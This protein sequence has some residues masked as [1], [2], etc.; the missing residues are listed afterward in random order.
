MRICLFEDPGVVNLEPLALTRPAFELLCGLTSLGRKQCRHFAPCEVGVLVRPELADLCRAA[1]PSLRVNDLGWLRAEQTVL[2][3]GRWLPPAGTIDQRCGPCAGMVGDEIAYA[4]IHADQLSYCSPNTIGDCLQ[5][6]KETLPSCQAGGRMIGYLWDLVALNGEQ[7][8]QDFDDMACP[9]SA[10]SPRGVAIVGPGEHCLIDPTAR[11]DPMVVI[12]T[13]GGPVVIDREA[14][15][16]AFTRIEGPC[17]I[18]P[19][20][21]LFG[22]K[23]RAGTTL[24]PQCRVGGEVECSIIHGHSNKYHDGFL[25]H[26]YVGEWVNLGAATNNSDLRNDYGRVSVWAA[27]RLVNTGQT[28]VGCFLGDHTKT[29]LGTLLNTGTNA[30]VFCNLLPSG[31]YLPRRVPSFTSWWN[32]ELRDNSDVPG[33]LT[34]AA[35]VMQRRQ[36]TLTDIHMRFF[37]NLYR[38]TVDERW[39][40]LRDDTQRR[41]RRSA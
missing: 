21:Q 2:V 6:W 14:V 17:Y 8:Q 4:V 18:G 37:D 28:K 30:G 29:G 15:V 24:G 27:G 39:S 10:A 32:G 36:Q 11:I 13:T 41:L 34:T 9:R 33:Q 5:V 26:S 16:T 40:V 31:G 3:N 1:R 20:T 23:V 25:G 35:D 7:I 22:A 38:Q 12:D 19:Q